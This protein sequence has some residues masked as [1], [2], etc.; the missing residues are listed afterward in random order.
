MK[1]Y[2]TPNT[3][4]VRLSSGEEVLTD[5]SFSVASGGGIQSSAMAPRRAVTPKIP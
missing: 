1:Y 2:Q 3:Q 5:T 4:L